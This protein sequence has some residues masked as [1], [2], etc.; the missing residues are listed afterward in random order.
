MTDTTGR[1]CKACSGSMAGKRAHAVYCSRPCK[2][3]ASEERRKADGRAAEKDRKKY[4]RSA[5]QRR[6]YARKASRQLR[7]RL[8]DHYGRECVQCGSSH[9]IEL[10]HVH[11]NGKQHRKAVGRGDA[12]YRWILAND[13]PA[14]C[15]AGGQF[16]LQPLCQHCHHLKTMRQRAE[17]G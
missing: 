8:L 2:A 10:D 14:D 7:E 3:K 6:E 11:G 16:E 5:E 13:F 9:R 17:R 15:E 1:S 4:Q 12:L